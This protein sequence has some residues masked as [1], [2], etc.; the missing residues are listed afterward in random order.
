MLL[1]RKYVIWN[2]SKVRGYTPLDSETVV[3]LVDAE[4]RMDAS[5]SSMVVTKDIKDLIAAIY[6]ETDVELCYA[7][8]KDY[9]KIQ[10][11]NFHEV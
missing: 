11:S 2:E 10:I 7:L 3:G 1:R 5:I 4:E 6:C 9:R 8:Y